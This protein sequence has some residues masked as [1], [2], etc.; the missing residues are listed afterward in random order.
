M[1]PAR[2]R[3]A[4]ARALAIDAGAVAVAGVCG[5]VSP[6]LRPGDVV[7]AEELRREGADAVP[8]E[9]APAVAHVLHG[10]GFRVHIGP[11]LSTDHLTKPAERRALADGDTL[12]VDM[13][14][15]WL[16]AGAGERPLAVVRVVADEA[17]RYLADPRI[18]VD[19]PRA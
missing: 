10:R 19:G 13:E 16:A 18:L 5:A 9:A 11:L 3:V 7:C 8:V 15:A 2:A 17:G 14:S 1:G 12:A 6:A 4:A